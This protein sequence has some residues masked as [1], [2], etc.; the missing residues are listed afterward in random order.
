[1]YAAVHDVALVVG[2]AVVNLF[3]TDPRITRILSRLDNG[4]CAF[5]SKSSKRRRLGLRLLKQIRKVMLNFLL[6]NERLQMINV[7]LCQKKKLSEFT[8]VNSSLSSKFRHIMFKGETFPRR[9]SDWR[10]TIQ[11]SY[12]WT[13]STWWPGHCE[14]CSKQNQK[15]LWVNYS[16]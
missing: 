14:H 3:N 7:L 4:N 10:D 2:T 8:V 5:R 9:G 6:K 1:M 12:G 13:K 16:T 11:T 15:G